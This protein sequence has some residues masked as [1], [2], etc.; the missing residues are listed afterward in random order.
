[1]EAI[2]HLTQGLGLLATLPD[3]QE[4]VQGEL[5]CQLSLGTSL[6]A[7]KGHAAPE[8][9]HAYARARR[10]CH[11]IGET[12]QLLVAL[13]GLFSFYLGKAAFQTTWDL[14]EELRTRALGGDGEHVLLIAHRV[15]ATTHFYRG[16]LAAARQHTQAGLTRYDPQRHRFLAF[17]YGQDVGVYCRVYAAW[18][19]W[20]LGYAD[21]ALQHSSKALTLAREL[22]HPFS[23]AV[24][25]NHAAYLHHFRGEE[26][27]TQEHA[28]EAIGL[29]TEQG[30]AFYL[31]MA[32]VVC[33]RVLTAQ[34]PPAAGIR[35]TLQGLTAWRASGAA[36]LVP[37]FLALLGESHGLAGQPEEGLALL[38]EALHMADTNGECWWK[39]ELYRLKGELLLQQPV[40]EAPQAEAC[41]RQA[42]A[43]AHHQ[44]A[45]SLE[46]RAAMSLSRLW[47]RQ[48]RQAEARELLAPIYGWFTEGFDTADLQGAKA[49]LEEL[50]R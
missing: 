1:V 34:P 14:G 7:T 4:R 33:G 45:K 23:L 31:A 37:T 36:I 47:Q 44:Q 18:T 27:V 35:Q 48:G 25:L 22:S 26:R 41:F 11:Q 12:P 3:T 42:L 50:G 29:C 2:A 46:L 8:V 17:Q 21:Q 5:A 20:V 28:E 24:A 16:E 19:L 30:F 15:L 6:L 40:P 49:L 43:V 39:A 32:N 38:D 13:Q 10:L 9:E